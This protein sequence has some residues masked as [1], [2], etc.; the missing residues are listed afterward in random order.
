MILY[1]L[2]LAF[3]TGYFFMSENIL[4]I[5]LLVCLVSLINA[6]HFHNRHVLTKACAHII[7]MMWPTIWH[8]AVFTL[9]TPMSYY[10]NMQ[11]KYLFLIAL[12]GQRRHIKIYLKVIE[13]KHTKC[14]NIMI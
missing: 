7:V 3:L 5:L 9:L 1:R 11:Y 12:Y 14:V 2:L 8:I 10:S 13:L 4:T 6:Q